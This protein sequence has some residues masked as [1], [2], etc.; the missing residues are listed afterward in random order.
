MYQLETSS[1]HRSKM[2]KFAFSQ[3]N[4]DL[5]V[6]ETSK[7]HSNKSYSANGDEDVSL[8]EGIFY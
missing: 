5:N 6:N 1:D 2:S 3:K 4:I 7:A 8:T